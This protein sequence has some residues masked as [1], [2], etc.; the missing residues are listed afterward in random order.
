MLFF[1]TH[2]DACRGISISII[3]ILLCHQFHLSLH[4]FFL[5]LFACRITCFMLAVRVRSFGMSNNKMSV[6]L[7]RKGWGESWIVSL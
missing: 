5:L 3:P 1:L 6:L 2:T 7:K 4:V